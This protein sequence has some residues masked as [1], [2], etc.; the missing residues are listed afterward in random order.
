MPWSGFTLTKKET[1]QAIAT[2]RCRFGQIALSLR[3]A[4]ASGRCRLGPRTG[5][6]PHLREGGHFLKGL[7]T[8]F[9]GRSRLALVVASLVFLD[10]DRG[11]LGGG[12]GF[13]GALRH[14]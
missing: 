4:V 5:A 13:S 14:V 1:A 12:G 11:G 8:R 10:L 2:L 3:A 6:R 7:Q 9:G